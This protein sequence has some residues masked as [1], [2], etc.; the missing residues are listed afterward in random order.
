MIKAIKKKIK[1]NRLDREIKLDKLRDRPEKFPIQLSP[2]EKEY[3]ESVFGYI[4]REGGGNYLE[5]GSGGSTFLALLTSKIKK[6]VSVESDANWIDYLMGWK[7]ISDSVNQG[8]LDF[9]KVD[10]GEVG[11]WG[12]PLNDEKKDLYPNYHSKVFEDKQDFDLVFID[13]RFRVACLCS[14]IIH[15]NRNIKI[16]IHD[17]NNRPY[18][19]KVIEFLDFIDT[20]DTLAEFKIRE[21][22]DKQKLLKLYEESKFIYD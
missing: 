8:R 18:Y 5:F 9:V 4:R 6:V 1:Q 12:V 21:N 10:I 14:S 11:E 16:L 2:N 22:I 13:G 3:L 19:H 20:C 7:I 15:C 17:F